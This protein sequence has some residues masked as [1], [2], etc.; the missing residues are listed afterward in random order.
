[1]Q[2]LRHRKVKYSA[3]VTELAC[4]G[5]RSHTWAVGPQSPNTM[6]LWLT[7]AQ[8]SDFPSG[9]HLTPYRPCDLDK[10]A[11]TLWLFGWVMSSNPGPSKPQIVLAIVVNSIVTPA[12]SMRT[13]PQSFRVTGMVRAARSVFVT[14]LSDKGN[15]SKSELRDWAQLSS[16]I[17][18]CLKYT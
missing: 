8:N 13:L 10:V 1:M 17:Q 4:G 12:R 9:T 2:T 16:W 14:C 7:P 6:S 5:S 15:T 18:P 11:H 3:K